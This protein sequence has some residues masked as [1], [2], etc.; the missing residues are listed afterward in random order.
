MDFMNSQET[1]QR[2]HSIDFKEISRTEKGFMLFTHL[3][4]PKISPFVTYL[5]MPIYGTTKI[6]FLN[7]I[8][9]EKF[10]MPKTKFPTKN[11]A[12]SS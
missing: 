8:I 1:K 10:K 5:G 11:V 7:T 12:Y 9:L 2:Y 4:V 6:S 3:F